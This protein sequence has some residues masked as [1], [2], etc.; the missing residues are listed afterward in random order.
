MELIDPAPMKTGL[1]PAPPGKRVTLNGANSTRV[2]AV[3]VNPKEFNYGRTEVDKDFAEEWFKR[4][5]TSAMVEEGHVFMEPNEDAFNAKAIEGH[6]VRT[7]LE[8]LNVEGT[9]PRLKGVETDKDHLKRLQ[10]GV[11]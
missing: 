2:I 5:K 6:S 8:P 7:G 10:A 1:I 11:R 4:N 3:S 9:D